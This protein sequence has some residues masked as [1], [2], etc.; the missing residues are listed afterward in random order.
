MLKWLLLLNVCS[1]VGCVE[2]LECFGTAI[3]VVYVYGI[4]YIAVCV[5]VSACVLAYGVGV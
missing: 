4:G 2:L 3:V 1:V 5:H